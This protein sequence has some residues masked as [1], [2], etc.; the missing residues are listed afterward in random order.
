MPAHA[1]GLY[2]LGRLRR[3]LSPSYELSDP[4]LLAAEE[5]RELAAECPYPGRLATARMRRG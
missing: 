5:G 4:T 3:W 1:E 2:G